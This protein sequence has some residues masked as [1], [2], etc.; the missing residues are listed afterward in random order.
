MTAILATA[1]ASTEV[2]YSKQG[3]EPPHLQQA[4]PFA[5]SMVSVRSEVVAVVWPSLG[6]AAPRISLASMFTLATSFTMQPIFRSL[7]CST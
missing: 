5:N 6:P 2:G 4:Q 1:T 7:C 3:P